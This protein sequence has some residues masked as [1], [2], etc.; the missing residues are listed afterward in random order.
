MADLLA[1]LEL[2]PHGL[3]LPDGMLGNGLTDLAF[4]VLDIG[5]DCFG[6]W[7]GCRATKLALDS[8]SADEHRQQQQQSLQ[9]G[10]TDQMYRA[11]SLA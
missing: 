2:L 7:L 6:S 10:H 9:A 11:A 4:D 5:L 1:R 8:G 3:H